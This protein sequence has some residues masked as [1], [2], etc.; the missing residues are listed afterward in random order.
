MSDKKKVK[1]YS[2]RNNPEDTAI[3]VEE[4]DKFKTVLLE[5]RTGENAGKTINIATST[6]KRW[7]KIAGEVEIDDEEENEVEKEE[8]A[9]EPEKFV[10]KITPTTKKT[11][12][13]I[14][15]NKQEK[16]DY[17]DILCKRLGFVSIPKK[18]HPDVIRLHKVEKLDDGSTKEKNF[19]EI[20]INHTSFVLYTSRIIILDQDKFSFIV[21]TDP[22][23]RAK[24]KFNLDDNALEYVMEQLAESEV[25]NNGKN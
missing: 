23:G 3:I 11:S 16:I 6:L 4:N 10:T 9:K 25:K 19:G 22:S 18:S 17:L 1:L 20:K 13:A 12:K 7:W 8:P 14:K 24:I 21:D 5:Y 2:N 15:I